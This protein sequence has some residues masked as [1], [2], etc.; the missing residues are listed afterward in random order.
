M[1]TGREGTAAAGKPEATVPAAPEW[2]YG[3]P[4][5]GVRHKARTGDISLISVVGMSQL[6]RY[7]PTLSP[8]VFNILKITSWFRSVEY[9]Q[10]YFLEVQPQTIHRANV[11]PKKGYDKKSLDPILGTA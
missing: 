9:L 4:R 6:F 3:L 2:A 10:N 8:H 5:A 7:H 1:S 11:P